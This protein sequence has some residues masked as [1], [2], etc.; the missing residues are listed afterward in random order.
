MFEAATMQATPKTSW[1]QREASTWSGPAD[2]LA[3]DDMRTVSYGT[4]RGND[5]LNF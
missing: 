2:V 5:D 4:I 3:L 1:P